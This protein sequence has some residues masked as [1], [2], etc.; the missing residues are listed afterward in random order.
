MTTLIDWRLLESK[1]ELN[2][3]NWGYEKRS[4][5][6][7]HVLLETL[8]DL[9]PEEIGDAITDGPQDRGI[10]AVH[11]EEQEKIVVHL[12]QFK[13]TSKFENSNDNFPSN[14]IDKMLSF[15]AAMLSKEASMKNNC[16]PLVWSKVQSIWDILD[17]EVPQFVVHLCGNMA[18]LTPNE[19]ER[20][21]T[22]LQPYRHFQIKQYSLESLVSLIIEKKV[23]PTNGQVHLVDKQYFERVDGNIRG[24]IATLPALELIDLIRDPDDPEKVLLDVFNDNV[25]VYLGAKKNPIN[26]KILESALNQSAEFWY[27]NNGITITCNS[28]E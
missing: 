17:R 18:E 4:Q 14:E 11:I 6:L 20:F 9:T 16:N 2:E 27:L 19:F 22:S 24:L 15:I 10:D 7:S 25:R 26:K 23:K 13:Y 1:V 12:F 8:F 28:F 21:K 3:N 5:A